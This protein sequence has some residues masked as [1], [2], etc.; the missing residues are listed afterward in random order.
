MTEDRSLSVTE[1]GLIVRKAFPSVE[2]RKVHSNWYYYGVDFREIKVPNASNEDTH[3]LTVNKAEKK[4]TQSI[5]D[6]GKLHHIPCLNI[7]LESLTPIEKCSSIGEGT[8]GMCV[9]G[10]YQNIPVAIKVLKG[11]VTAN[12]VHKEANFLLKIPSHPNIPILIGVQ[13]LTRPYFLLTRL[14]LS[15]GKPKTYSSYLHSLNTQ[16]VQLKECMHL[17]YE[18]ASAIHHVHLQKII[19]NDIKGNNIVIEDNKGIHHAMLVDF[20]KAKYIQDIKSKYKYI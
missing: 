4:I 1:C 6:E 8:F 3:N 11:K 14:C 20:G 12:I 10:T 5:Q 2:R 15:N 17:L 19:H 9:A 18:I 13:T 16:N 7:C